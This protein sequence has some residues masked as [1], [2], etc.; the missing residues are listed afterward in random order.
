[1]RAAS[2]LGSPWVCFPLRELAFLHGFRL[3]RQALGT[4]GQDHNENTHHK[5]HQGPEEAM[6]EDNLIVRA[7]QE[8]V[9]WSV[10][11]WTS[12]KKGWSEA[13]VRHRKRYN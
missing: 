12:G 1:M 5:C 8:H 3:D 13:W 7:M 4:D 6:Q 10:R 9:V 2:V 11:Q